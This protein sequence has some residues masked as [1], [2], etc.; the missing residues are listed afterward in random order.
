MKKALIV[1]SF[2]TTHHDTRKRTIEAIEQQLAAEFPQ[3]DF[4][5]AWTALMIINKLKKRDGMEVPT[6]KQVLARLVEDGYTDV[7]IQPTHVTPGVEF[8]RV[9]EAV[10]AFAGMFEKLSLGRPL[11]Y[12]QG[13]ESRG[14]EMPD[15]YVPVMDAY[16]TILPETSDQH[17]VVLFG[18]GT[19]HP[20]NAIYAALQA[21]YDDAG[22]NVLVGTVDAYPELDDVR[23]RLRQRGVQRVTLVP[24]MVVAG[25]HVKNDMAGDEEDSWKSILQADGY[26]VDVVMRG[27]GEMPA[28][29]DIFVQHAR[30][31]DVYPVW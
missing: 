1:V 17:A 6:V 7:L 14:R 19:S 28:F 22:Q 25:D 3:R 18:H 5:R 23:R 10:R 11:I 4:F 21:R 16:T 20:A 15:D 13:G 31:A 30:T 2:G 9:Q 26:Q 8:V 24:F 27:L 29:R 12:F